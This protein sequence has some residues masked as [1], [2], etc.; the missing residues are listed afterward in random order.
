MSQKNME[1]AKRAMN[2]F[3]YSNFVLSG[4]TPFP[5]LREFCDPDVEWDFSRRVIDGD[6]YHGYEGWMR[7]AEGVR[8]ACQEFRFA[9]EEIV[10]AGE[11]VVVI[12]RNTGLAES[13]IRLDAG[14]AQTL[15]FRDAKVVT[16]RYFGEDRAA[17]L[18]AV[19][20]AV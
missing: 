5:S 15:T 19:G 10:D 1:I 13:G 9:A 14:V 4:A 3:N 6:I 20:L 17:C 7:F 11:S 12:S 18:E 16:Y 8:E 2:S